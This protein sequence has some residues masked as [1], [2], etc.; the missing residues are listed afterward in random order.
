[1]V[2]IKIWRI[3]QKSIKV[4]S[5]TIEIYICQVVDIDRGTT[6][7]SFLEETGKQVYKKPNI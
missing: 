1:M 5:N 3:L 2:N 7:D 6:V 4:K